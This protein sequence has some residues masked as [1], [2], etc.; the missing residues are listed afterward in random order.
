[1]RFR[2]QRAARGSNRIV[3][4]RRPFALVG[5]APGA[6]IAVGDRA[7][8]DRHVYIHL[9]H[10]GVYAVDLATPSGTR[11][12]G[13]CGSA[14]WLRPGDWL[15]VAGSRIE[16]LEARIDGIVQDPPPCAA[17]LLADTSRTTLAGVALEPQRSSAGPSWVLNSELV[18]AGRSAACGIPIKDHT[19]ARIHAALLRT[20]SAVY[21][22]DLHGRHTWIDGRPVRGAMLIAS[23]H[24]LALGSAQFAI[25]V[26]PGAPLAA[27][28]ELAWT[29]QNALAVGPVNAG[30]PAGCHPPT[31]LETSLSPESQ[32]AILA[33]MMGTVQGSQG[34]ALRQQGE[35]Q[36]A[37]AQLLHRI[38]QDNAAL[39]AAHLD[40]IENLDRALAALRAEFRQRRIDESTQ[41]SLPAPLPLSV[42][43]LPP[44]RPLSIPRAMPEEPSSQTSTTWLLQRLGQL[45]DQNRP[46]WREFLGRFL[47]RPRRAT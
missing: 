47:L 33:W 20:E 25:T 35:L 40:R 10:R 41:M 31:L 37:L 14:G 38:Q 39:L 16:L 21:V 24:V 46:A 22:I 6:D 5:Q 30:V 4:V 13:A 19:V 42:P 18:F 44:V 2:V 32:Q 28:P 26:A 1:M 45:E 11:F 9:D 17:D 34:E 36:H 8:S 23:G 15:E 7:A 27:G 29:G 3:A 43:P 12:G